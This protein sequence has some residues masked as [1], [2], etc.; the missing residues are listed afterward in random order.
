MAYFVRGLRL[1]RYLDFWKAEEYV[2]RIT[3]Q[4]IVGM[5][6]GVLVPIQANAIGHLLVNP[7]FDSDLAG[8]DNLYARPAYWQPLDAEDDPGSG[9]VRLVN[10]APVGNGATTAILS[11]CIPVNVGH[12]YAFGAD[13]LLP[14]GQ[15]D[16]TQAAVMIRMFTSADCG[17]GGADFKSA[18]TW[19]PGGWQP[20]ANEITTLPGIQSMR[21]MLG[22]SKPDGVTVETEA[23]FDR[24]YLVDLDDDTVFANGFELE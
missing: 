18:A 19:D 1:F 11:Q 5:V 8:W 20:V 22:V 12:A 6:V 3:H 2:E 14:T 16:F 23:Y 9:S 10:D 7:G 15:A 17:L 21:L 24:I 13:V 4:A